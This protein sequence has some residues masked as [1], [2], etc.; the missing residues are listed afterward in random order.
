[1]VWKKW[2]FSASQIHLLLIKIWFSTS[3]FGMK[4][5]PFLNLQ[6]GMCNCKTTIIDKM[7]NAIFLLLTTLLLSSWLSAPDDFIIGTWK[8]YKLET[9]NKKQM[10]SDSIMLNFKSEITFFKDSTY[11]KITNGLVSTGKFLKE[12][13]RITFLHQDENK[14]WIQDWLIRWPTGG[15]DPYPR[16]KEVDIVYPELIQVKD[17]KG[18]IVNGEVDVFYI[19]ENR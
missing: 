2:R 18:N 9:I 11:K 4:S 6:K 17:Q 10:L 1:M 14:K 7:K 8:S 16:T 13:N 12:N 3:I 19:K 5:P 15:N